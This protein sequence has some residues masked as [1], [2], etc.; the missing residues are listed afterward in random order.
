MRKSSIFIVL[1]LLL[2]SR[3]TPQLLMN[4]RVPEILRMPGGSA[5]SLKEGARLQRGPGIP[6]YKEEQ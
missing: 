3:E 6:T 4:R 1:P 2:A 5:P